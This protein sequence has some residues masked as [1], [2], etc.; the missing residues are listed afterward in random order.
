MKNNRLKIILGILASISVIIFVL[1][2]VKIKP[3]TTSD[4]ICKNPDVSD[5]T[6]YT[7]SHVI[8]NSL[9]MYAST[10]YVYGIIFWLNA[11]LEI[12]VVVMF[13]LSLVKPAKW[14]CISSFV[15]FGILLTRFVGMLLFFR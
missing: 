1:S 7:T 15:A 4:Y 3:V 10:Y 11:G 12:Y 8:F 6:C 13:I 14:M 9:Y 5:E 2:F